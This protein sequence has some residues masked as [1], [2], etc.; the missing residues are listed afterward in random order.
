MDA[1]GQRVM[2]EGFLR[3]LKS[4]LGDSSDINNVADWLCNNTSLRGD[5]WGYKYHEYQVEI[6]NCN[7]RKLTVKKCSQVGLS[8]L[9]LRKVLAFVNI[10]NSI[11]AIY[12]LPSAVIARKFVKGRFDPAISGSKIMSDNLNPKVN[13]TEMKQFSNSF[14]YINGSYGQSSAI[15]TP[16]EMVVQDEVDFCDPKVLTTYAARLRHAVDGGYLWKFSTPTVGGYGI[17]ESFNNSDQRYYLCKC[18]CGHEGVPNFYEDTVIPGYND[19][20]KDFRKSVVNDPTVDIAGAMILCPKCRKPWPVSDPDRR[21]WVAAKSKVRDHVG[22][23]V[24]PWDVPHFNSMSVILNQADNYDTHMDWTNFVLGEEYTDSDNSFVR[25]NLDRD[26]IVSPV[27]PQEGKI[28]ASDCVMGVDIGKTSWIVIGK[29]TNRGL[30]ILYAEKIQ[31]KSGTDIPDRVVVLFVMYGVRRVVIDAGPEFSTVLRVISSPKV[32]EGWAYGCYYV[33]IDPK[34]MIDISE[35]EGW[36]F[37][38]HR[39]KSLNEIA[40]LSANNRLLLP[41]MGET[42]IIKSHLLALKHID[43]KE[44]GPA[45]KIRSVWISTGPDHYGHAINYCNVA[46]VT[47][48]NHIGIYQKSVLPSVGSVKL[49]NKSDVDGPSRGRLLSSERVGRLTMTG[50]G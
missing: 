29:M 21:R 20:M 24:N 8:E 35:R 38:V 46:A 18:K 14:L 11:N 37:H 6:A 48:G 26:T 16:A 7:A 27:L 23:Q 47:L 50:R 13:S 3:R 31:E 36:V 25:D 9:L 43:Q 2:Q 32:P 12:T 22:Y 44:K 1:G 42:Q 4:A 41:K 45:E 15:S 10:M 30:E 17:S 49:L 28:V 19:S 39:T 34:K 40:S 5:L 33:D